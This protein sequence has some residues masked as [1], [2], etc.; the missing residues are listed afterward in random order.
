MATETKS[1]KLT[2]ENLEERKVMTAGVAGQLASAIQPIVETEQVQVSTQD[3]VDEG[4]LNLV[5]IGDQ[6]EDHGHGDQC[7]C[8]VCTGALK[9][10]IDDFCEDGHIHDEFVAGLAEFAAEFDVQAALD[11]GTPAPITERVTVQ[12]IIV[13]NDDG[14]N[15]ATYFGSASEEA[16]IHDLI[17]Q[18]WAQAGIDVDWLEPTSWNSTEANVGSGTSSNARSQDDLTSIV[19]AGD[20]AGVGNDDALVVDM[21]FV[22]IAAGFRQLGNNYANGLA[23]VGGNGIT[24]HVGDNLTSFSAGRDVVARVVAHEIGH[25]LGLYHVNDAVNLMDDGERLT[26]S[27][28]STTVDSELSVIL[29]A[30]IS[31]LSPGQSVTSLN[32]QY[33]ATLQTDGNFVIYNNLTGQPAWH[34]QT[35]GQT[36]TEAVVQPDGNFVLYNGGTPVWHASTYGNSGAELHLDNAG[37]LRLVSTLGDTVWTSGEEIA[38]LVP[39]DAYF[40]SQ[41]N[42]LLTLQT[43]GNLVLYDTQSGSPLWHTSTFGEPVSAVIMQSDGNFVM[44]SESGVIWHAST[45]GNPDASLVLDA[46]GLKIVSAAGELVWNPVA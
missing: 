19:N 13:S 46:E 29:P 25:N 32:S 3:D 44:Y 21:Y 39:G 12:P 4:A 20:N 31:S 6:H 35:Y 38:A 2:L 15:T 1:R 8:D 10:H 5:T 17:D 27:Q 23:Y 7:Q 18:I 22:E 37:T 14:S 11:V 42:K 41:G 9:S 45:F 40:S 30:T 43:D 36:V 34:T 16:I 24:M 26:A 28:V 33:T